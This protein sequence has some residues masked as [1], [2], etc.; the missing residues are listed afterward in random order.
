MY[1]F[2]RTVFISLILAS[3]VINKCHYFKRLERKKT[4]QKTTT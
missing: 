4:Q 1:I 2:D 3:T